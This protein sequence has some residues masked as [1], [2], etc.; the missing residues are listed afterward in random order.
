VRWRVSNACRKRAG[1]VEAFA[2]RA[3][4]EFSRVLQGTE[5]VC[6]DLFCV[7]RATVESISYSIVARATQMIKLTFSPGLERPG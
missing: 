3:A 7:A 4:H 5:R 2:A 1:D 6:K